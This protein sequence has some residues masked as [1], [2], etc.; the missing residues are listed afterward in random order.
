MLAR[1]PPSPGPARGRLGAIDWARPLQRKVLT[2]MRPRIR[3]VVRLCLPLA[4]AAAVVGTA[5]SM[6]TRAGAT[7]SASSGPAADAGW[8][9]CND[10]GVRD[11]PSVIWTRI[12]QVSFASHGI[13]RSFYSTYRDDIAKI[14]CYESTYNWHAENAGQYGWF[15][16]SKSLISSEGVSFGEYWSGNRSHPA[17]WYQCL[18]GERYIRARYGTPAA[19]WSHEYNYGW[20]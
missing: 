6:T 19:A 1:G 8:V 5:G 11:T 4:S 2:L 9:R 10:T 14:I 13:P 18:S 15:Q 12:D 3:L 17:G 16:M 20:Y 7:I